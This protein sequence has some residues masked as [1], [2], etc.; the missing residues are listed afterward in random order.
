MI[1]SVI[2]YSASMTGEERPCH[3][4][5]LATLAPSIAT[6]QCSMQHASTMSCTL[7]HSC[8]DTWY[9][10]QGEHLEQLLRLVDDK[11]LR[12][13]LPTLPLPSDS[14]LSGSIAAQHRPG[15]IPLLIRVLYPKIR[16]RSNRL[17]GGHC[18]FMKG[19]CQAALYLLPHAAH[20]TP[21]VSQT[22][23]LCAARETG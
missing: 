23:V 9:C 17:A 16:K 3:G 6:M 5:P 7:L 22:A 15:L 8:L 19:M 20:H 14:T 4:D 18:I 1:T 12:E 2:T 21:D 11:T 10:L 13:Q